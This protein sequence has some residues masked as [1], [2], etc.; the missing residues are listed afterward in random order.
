[1][2]NRR[3]RNKTPLQ[4]SSPFLLV[5]FAVALTGC[6]PKPDDQGYAKYILGRPPPAGEANIARECGFL[7]QEIARQTA[8]AQALPTNDMLPETAAAIQKATQTN[9]AALKQR[10]AQLACPLPN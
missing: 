8:A 6:A 4:N 2:I 3:P 9:I 1:M 5:A 10:A 7:F